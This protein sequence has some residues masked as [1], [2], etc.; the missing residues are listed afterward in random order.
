MSASYYCFSWGAKLPGTATSGGICTICQM[1]I[2][3][4]NAP[5]AMAAQVVTW[6]TIMQQGS[7]LT[8]G[9]DAGLVNTANY[10]GQVMQCI[11]EHLADTKAINAGDQGTIWDGG[12]TV[13]VDYQGTRG[14]TGATF[15]IDIQGQVGGSGKKR[16]SYWQI[17]VECGPAA[18]GQAVVE[19]AI[20]ASHDSSVDSGKRTVI[21]QRAVI[22]RSTTAGRSK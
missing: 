18:P 1:K 14:G 12:G 9:R 19:A 8:A 7:A 3:S 10:I 6:D 17:M 21:G 15:W 20:R 5:V 13:T 11:D 22:V 16:K 2:T 4:K